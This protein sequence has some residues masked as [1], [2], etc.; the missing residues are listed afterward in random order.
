MIIKK[1]KRYIKYKLKHLTG[2][3]THFRYGS[4]FAYKNILKKI[5]QL[6]DKE[7]DKRK[8]IKKD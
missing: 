7:N 6:E 1:L 4:E 5:K 3:T 2:G 8:S